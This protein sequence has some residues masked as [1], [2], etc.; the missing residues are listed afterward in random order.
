MWIISFIYFIYSLFNSIIIQISR[1]N[2]CLIETEMNGRPYNIYSFILTRKNVFNYNH[3]FFFFLTLLLYSNPQLCIKLTQTE[4]INT[5]TESEENKI[6]WNK[7]FVYISI[8]RHCFDLFDL[9]PFAFQFDVSMF[10]IKRKIR[11]KQRKQKKNALLFA[12]IYLFVPSLIQI[13]MSHWLW[14]NG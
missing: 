11:K 14:A 8:Y 1:E 12:R 2:H 6:K 10:T 4:W 3:F 9:L 13:R 7:K 5:W